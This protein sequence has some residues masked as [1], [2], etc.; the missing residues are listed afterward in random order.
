MNTV[1]MSH[2]F[3]RVVS[4]FECK[5][6]RASKKA[7]MIIFQGISMFSTMNFEGLRESFLLVEVDIGLS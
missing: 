1:K 5:I 3:K 2:L 7:I 6:K 4:C